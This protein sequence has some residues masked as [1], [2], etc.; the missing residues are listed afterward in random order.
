M[1]QDSTG[2]TTRWVMPLTAPEA[3]G[4]YNYEIVPIL[5]NYD[6]LYIECYLYATHNT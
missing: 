4:T 6:V 2:I 3:R 5:N 1:A